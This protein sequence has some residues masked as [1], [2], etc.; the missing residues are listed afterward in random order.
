VQDMMNQI[1]ASTINYASHG[2]ILLWAAISQ[3]IASRITKSKAPN[4][5]H[6][7]FFPAW[8]TPKF[9]RHVPKFSHCLLLIKMLQ[10]S[11]KC[12]AEWP[13]YIKFNAARPSFLFFF[14][15]Y[16]QRLVLKCFVLARII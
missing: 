10:S 11:G 5:S 1:S 2:N 15:L 13:L 4:F 3:R 16:E 12:M 7:N 14:F 9:S 6:L 8:G